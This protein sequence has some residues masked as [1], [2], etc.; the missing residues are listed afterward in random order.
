MI[1]IYIKDPA[2]VQ[3]QMCKI[4]SSKI[5]VSKRNISKI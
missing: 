2:K 5:H 1:Q 3:N 4:Q